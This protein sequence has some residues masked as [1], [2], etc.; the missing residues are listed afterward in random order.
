MR[1]VLI[2]DD[3]PCASQMRPHLAPLGFE[4]VQVMRAEEGLAAVAQHGPDLILLDLHF[5]EDGPDAS[6]TTGGMLHTTLRQEFSHIPVLIFSTRTQDNDIAPES[7]EID[8]LGRIE[9]PNTRAPDWA[10]DFAAWL[11]RAITMFSATAS[12]E[13][14]GFH[15][16]KTQAMH[17]LARA[18][19]THIA[20]RDQAV[21]K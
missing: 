10:F 21:L 7:F 11:E 20:A 12:L 15:I 2:I 14:V 17:S 5:P 18:I 9:K 4:I 3:V 6:R 8:P 1:K 13:A 19:R 16:G